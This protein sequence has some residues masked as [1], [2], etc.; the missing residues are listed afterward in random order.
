M[1]GMIFVLVYQVRGCVVDPLDLLPCAPTCCLEELFQ[2]W[3]S[4]VIETSYVNLIADENVLVEVIQICL[5][6]DL[7]LLLFGELDVLERELVPA[8]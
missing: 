1:T 6:D 5:G 2:F 3:L 8:N 4:Q 7:I